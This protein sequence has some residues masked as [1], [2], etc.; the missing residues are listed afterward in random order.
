MQVQKRE[1]IVWRRVTR[2]SRPMTP[3][4]ID[5][6]IADAL[7]LRSKCTEQVLNVQGMSGAMTRHLWEA[8]NPE[9]AVILVDDW[10]W[11]GVRAGTLRGLDRVGAEVLHRRELR[12][13][14]GYGEGEGEGTVPGGEGGFWNGC[15]VFLVRREKV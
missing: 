2:Q 9:A 10:D 4:A 13:T 15:G 12:T 14:R 11:N 8:L 7:A 6:A 3:D 5:R 1:K